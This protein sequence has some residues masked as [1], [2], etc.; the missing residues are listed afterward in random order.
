MQD[1]QI[2][3]INITKFMESVNRFGAAQEVPGAI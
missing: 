1:F 3:F 2:L